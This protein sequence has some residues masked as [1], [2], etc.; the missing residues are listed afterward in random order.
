MQEVF[1]PG[2]MD[3]SKAPI[4]SDILRLFDAQRGQ[5]KFEQFVSFVN[6]DGL[7]SQMSSSFLEFLNQLFKL[8]GKLWEPGSCRNINSMVDPA[9]TVL[10]KSP[11]LGFSS[12]NPKRYSHSHFWLQLEI[13]GQPNGLIVDP[14]GV[15]IDHND[16]N[17]KKI[18]PY[19]GPIEG[20]KDFAKHVYRNAQDIDD[21]RYRDLPP[22]FHP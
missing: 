1:H 9:K 7:T 6:T 20:A 13:I 15:P 21:W 18:L 10:E 17:Q 12:V 2:Y 8:T 22:G 5:R 4:G 3:T 19:F 14:T 11:Q 16:Y